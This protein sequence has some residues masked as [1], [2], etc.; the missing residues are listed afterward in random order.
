MSVAE[1]YE[2]DFFLWTQRN[3]KLLREGN[4]GEADLRRIAEEIED[5]GKRDRRTLVSKTEVLVA[6]LLKWEFQPLKRSKSWANTIRAQRRGIAK[7]LRDM[8]SLSAYLARNLRE[9][10]RDAVVLAMRDTDLDE[11]TFPTACPYTVE[12]VRDE[13]FLPGPL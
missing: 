7:E 13:A 12:Q 3:A 11:E 2:K 1:L 5:M 10:Y 9:I 4:V 6:H 8:P